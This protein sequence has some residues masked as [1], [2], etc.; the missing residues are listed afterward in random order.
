MV[1]ILSIIC[2]MGLIILIVAV[3]EL[4]SICKNS[5]RKKINRLGAI[6]VLIQGIILVL[7]SVS[8]LLRILKK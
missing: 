7:C 4:Y 2:V 1:V 6:S 8:A 5:Y 3:I